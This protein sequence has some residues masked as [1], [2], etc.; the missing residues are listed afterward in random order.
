MNLMAIVTT[1]LLLGFS[2]AAYGVGDEKDA[3]PQEA[4]PTNSAIPNISDGNKKNIGVPDESIKFRK[5]CTLSKDERE[6]N[7]SRILYKTNQELE[8]CYLKL[9]FSY[10][11]EPFDKVVDQAFEMELTDNDWA[12]EMQQLLSK[13]LADFPKIKLIEGGCRTSLCRYDF[14]TSIGL[15]ELAN[16]LIGDAAKTLY[17]I[18]IYLPKKNNLP[19][20]PRLYFFSLIPPATWTE[21]IP[22]RSLPKRQSQ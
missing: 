14:S 15:H 16:K 12:I 19:I 13:N 8:I 1:I 21:T 7:R 2:V 5:S 11:M 4:I 3:T 17:P 22:L 10:G 18:Q 6:N 9:R 20:A